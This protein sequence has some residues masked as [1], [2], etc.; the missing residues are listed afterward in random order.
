[1]PH[2]IFLL[3]GLHGHGTDFTNF[4]NVIKTYDSSKNFSLIHPI[5]NYEGRTHDGIEALGGLAKE[6]ILR[7][8]SDFTNTSINPNPTHTK[9]HINLTIVG[10]SLG[11]LVARMAVKLL[12]EDKSYKDME[13]KIDIQ[14][15][16]FATFASPHVG[17][18][19][20]N[21][22]FRKFALDIYT[23]NVLSRTGEDLMLKNDLLLRMANGDYTDALNRFGGIHL[24]S[25]VLNDFAVPYCTSS[26]S[27]ENPYNYVESIE[28][29]QG[30]SCF[31]EPTSR[32]VN[33]GVNFALW[34][35][36]K[37]R[38]IYRTLGLDGEGVDNEEDKDEIA[39]V[40][41]SLAKNLDEDKIHRHD[42]AI[43]SPLSHSYIVAK[44]PFSDRFYEIPLHFAKLVLK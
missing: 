23:G 40:Y 41:C 4:I 17:S 14:P 44:F 19:A 24:Y 21:N 18:R 31:I 6:E 27:W 16:I 25:N 34:W 7:T 28:V 43:M 5:T 1:M 33:S 15:H 42:V 22:V 32:E 20:I 13:T 26:M 36:K 9:T 30:C 2:I 39:K 12:F 29:K 11:G 35:K 38:G 3:H 10:H 8:L 37:S